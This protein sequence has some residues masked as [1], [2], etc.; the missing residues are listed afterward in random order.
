MNGIRA[1]VA[2]LDAVAS[3]AADPV[4]ERQTDLR[5]LVGE[6][7]SRVSAHPHG[8]CFR[9]GSGAAIVIPRGVMFDVAGLPVIEP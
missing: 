8:I 2:C 3:G 5:D 9:F 7:V 4:V 6:E 1:I